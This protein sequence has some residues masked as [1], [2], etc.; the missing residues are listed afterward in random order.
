MPIGY[1]WHDG[2]VWFRSAGGTKLAA[3]LDAPVAFEIDGTDAQYHSGWSV[4]V[5]GRAELVDDA[6]LLERLESLPVPRWVPDPLPNWV[7]IVPERISGRRIPAP[8][9]HR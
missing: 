1:V 6:A 8:F 7:R 4:I 2:C 9:E 3:A 5:A